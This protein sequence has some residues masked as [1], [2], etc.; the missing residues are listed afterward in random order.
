MRGDIDAAEAIDPDI[1][2]H[3]PAQS[4][5]LARGHGSVLAVIALGG[6]LGS[7]ARFGVSRLAPTTP[8][9]FPW[10]TFVVNLSGCLLIGVLMT[11]I[12]E[13]WSGHRLLRPF[14]GVGV[15]GGYTTF[16]TYAVEITGLLT[17]G[18]PGLALAYLVG[19]LA[20]AM[21][22]VVAGAWVT[23]ALASAGRRARETSGWRP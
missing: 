1:D 4:R 2:V 22:A 17:D 20:G 21:L 18:A 6:G 19:T 15:L 10:G 11:L 3:V 14:L 12:S 8:G 9:H 13:V 16:S 5:E 7:L 23:R